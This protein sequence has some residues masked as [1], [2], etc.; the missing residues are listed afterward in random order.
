MVTFNN[1]LAD[2]DGGVVN[3]FHSAI[4]TF[5]GNSE[6]IFCNNRALGDGGTMYIYD[7]QAYVY[8]I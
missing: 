7:D 2:T 5:N 1:S 3:I 6:V 4:I 8:H